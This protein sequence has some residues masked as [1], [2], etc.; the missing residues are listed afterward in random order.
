M[1]DIKTPAGSLFSDRRF[2][3]VWTVGIL[4]SVVRWLEFLAVGIFAYD[5]TGSAFL[6]AL[7]ALL[8][9]Y[10]LRCLVLYLAHW[11]T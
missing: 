9:S 6:V 5:V 2:I 7:L 4:V 3:A 11:A 1:T 10:L 8:D